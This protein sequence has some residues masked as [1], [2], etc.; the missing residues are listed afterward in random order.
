MDSGRAAAGPRRSTRART[1]VAACTALALAAGM[2]LAA[3]AAQ[4]DEAPMPDRTAVR[5]KAAA[6]LPTL[7]LPRPASRGAFGAE[8]GGLPA[9]PRSDVDGDGRSDMISQN[10]AGR[11]LVDPVNGEPY[12]YGFEDG[13]NASPGV[14]YKDVF[15]AAGLRADSTV[16]FTLTQTGRLS[17]YTNY[18]T[19]GQVFWSGQG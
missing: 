9:E 3:P 18:G 12:E 11:V 17:A 7:E 15:S 8:A 2:L 1:R 19:Y 4:A 13:V 16:V 5:P 10:V 6:P 14:F